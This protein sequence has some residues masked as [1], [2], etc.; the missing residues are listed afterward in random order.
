M[1]GLAFL[2]AFNIPGFAKGPPN[3]CP[4]KYD[5]R[6]SHEGIIMLAKIKTLAWRSRRGVVALAIPVTL[7]IPASASAAS[8]GPYY[9]NEANALSFISGRTLTSVKFQLDQVYG[10]NV[11]AVNQA[12]ATAVR[13]RDCG[14][15][16]IGFQILVAAN[17]DPANINVQNSANATNNSCATCSVVAAAYQIVDTGTAQ[18]RLTRQ[19]VQQLGQIHAQLQSLQYSQLSAAQIQ[20]QVAALANQAVSILQSGV[21]ATPV[22]TPAVTPAI[23]AATGP[24][25]N[26]AQLAETNKPQVT[27]YA[28][29]QHPTG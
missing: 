11:N 1:V 7:V 18:P 4:V 9:V 3:C 6:T 8:F 19:Q 25:F 27:L 17:K 28:R 13:C 10:S 12:N 21:V 15:V 29:F 24:S 23:T 20:T 16:A 2:E 5:F 26:A 22:V 14:A